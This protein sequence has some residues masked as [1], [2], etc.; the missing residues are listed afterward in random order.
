MHKPRFIIT[1]PRAT[2][3]ELSTL[4]GITPE[5]LRQ[6]NES[7]KPVLEKIR[8]QQLRGKAPSTRSKKVA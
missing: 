7:L 6:V 1:T 8:K 4:V 2:L 5:E 3:E